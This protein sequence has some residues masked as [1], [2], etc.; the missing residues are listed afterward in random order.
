MMPEGYTNAARTTLVLACQ[1]GDTTISVKSNLGFPINATF[2]IVIDQEVMLAGPITSTIWPVLRAYEAFAGIQT[3]VSHTNGSSVSH[4]QT[5]GGMLAAINNIVTPA[6]VNRSETRGRKFDVR[7]APYNVV[8]PPDGSDCSVGFQLAIDAAGDAATDSFHGSIVYVPSPPINTF[9]SFSRPFY[10]DRNFVAI[11]SDGPKACFLQ[12]TESFPPVVMAVSRKQGGTAFVEASHFVA[13][14]GIMDGSQPAGYGYNLNGDAYLVFAR[15]PFEIGIDDGGHWS[16]LSQFTMSFAAKNNT[17]SWA[18]AVAAIMGLDSGRGTPSLFTA[19]PF[20]ITNVQN[21]TFAL[22]FRT[23]DGLP[24]RVY[25]PITNTTQL[26]KVTIQFDFSVPSITAWVNGTK[27]TLDTTQINYGW[28]AGLRFVE[29]WYAQFTFGRSL[30]AYGTANNFKLLGCKFTSGLKYTSA[31]T[32]ALVGGG[33]LNDSRMFYSHDRD[34]GN[35]ILDFCTLDPVAAN[36]GNNQLIPWSGVKSSD[37]G[38]CNGFGIFMKNLV[39]V[40]DTCDGLVLRKIG[41]RQGGSSY[42]HV[43]SFGACYHPVIEDMDVI[44]GAVGLGSVQFS[45]AYKLRLNN[46]YF[47]YNSDAP[48]DLWGVIAFSDGCQ[49]ENWGRTTTIAFGCSLVI[50][51]PFLTPG[52]A[53]KRVVS[54]FGPDAVL[55]KWMIDFEGG[56]PTESYVHAELGN[57]IGNAHL[58]INDW[59]AGTIPSN[60]PYVDLVSVPTSGG[61]V[62]TQWGQGYVEVNRSFTSQAT[63]PGALA[64]VRVD[65]NLWQGVVNGLPLSTPPLTAHAT[66]PNVSSTITNEMS[67]LVGLRNV[68]AGNSLPAVG[69]YSVTTLPNIL[70]WHRAQTMGLGD[71]ASVTTLTDYSLRGGGGLTGTKV[72]GTITY[73]VNKYNSNRASLSYDGASYFSLAGATPTNGPFTAIFAAAPSTAASLAYLFDTFAGTYNH[74]VKVLN[75]TVACNNSVPFLPFAAYQGTLQVFAIR[76]TASPN[77]VLELWHNL[78]KFASYQLNDDTGVQWSAG[79]MQLGGSFQYSQ[80]YYT[81]DLPEDILCD[82]SLTDAKL[83]NSIQYLINDYNIL[84]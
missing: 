15:S 49:F 67:V 22:D 80:G 69:G 26:Q 84:V 31:S 36:S 7:D 63:S 59:I 43:I 61:I 27:A 48:L 30:R 62:T 44:G 1:A 60:V 83:T 32:Q 70:A 51:N 37:K 34:D 50:S 6:V 11:E 58:I 35:S 73:H 72:G 17:A 52:G 42:G 39:G 10:H 24:R 76:V 28:I 3:A 38:N 18:D 23:N 19:E 8:Y 56:G 64:I 57:D 77:R 47:S 53:C 16:T 4:V 29:N 54:L 45:V 78:N 25:I 5:V 82:G 68:P 12:S 13:L 40:P 2:R 74:G 9:Y 21:G 71:L 14:A 81:G 46:V 41:I 55:D 66:N 33:V 20:A 75:G 65:S 79:N